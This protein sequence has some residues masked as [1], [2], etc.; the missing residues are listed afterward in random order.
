MLN[1]T[2]GRLVAGAES[3]LRGGGIEEFDRALASQL[4]PDGLSVLLIPDLRSD[5]AGALPGQISEWITR[6]R[7]WD[8][9][10][11]DAH[12]V[13]SP[14]ETILH[15][16]WED[17]A[18]RLNRKMEA[19]FRSVALGS[20]GAIVCFFSGAAL[21]VVVGYQRSAGGAL[22]LEPVAAL[23]GPRGV[24]DLSHLFSGASPEQRNALKAAAQSADK[25]VFQRGVLVHV[26]RQ[27]DDVFGPTIDTVLLAEI[28]ARWLEDQDQEQ[29]RDIVALEVGPGNGLLSCLL[30]TAPHVTRLYAIELNPAAVVCTLRNLQINSITLDAVHPRVAVRAERFDE[31]EISGVIDVIVCNPPYIPDPPLDGTGY[32]LAVGGFSLCTEL[33]EGLDS[34]LS[35]NGRLL[36]MSSSVSHAEV[37]ACV[38]QGFRVVPCLDGKGLRVPLDVDTVWKNKDWRKHLVAE[39]RIEADPEGN[40]WHYLQPLWISRQTEEG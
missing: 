1:L 13:L 21:S 22:S 4:L 25:L 29:D 24:F 37:L 11:Y 3:S 2:R 40:L 20:T 8:V 32:G 5:I 30:A 33:L 36:L 35:P 18:G 16:L 26:H 23:E 19:A 38:P 34:L 14:A 39:E 15:R 27:R 7:T 31:G 9:S 17:L 10:V 28:L 12:T 6:P